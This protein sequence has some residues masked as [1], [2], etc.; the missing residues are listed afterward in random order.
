MD[1]K[2]SQSGR[3]VDRTNTH[4]TNNDNNNTHHK[5]LSRTTSSSTD[6]TSQSLASI[7]NNPHAV[8]SGLYDPSSWSGWWSSSAAATPL[9]F[10]PLSSTS[11]AAA[12]V[13]DPT[14]SD[15]QPYLSSISGP[16]GRFKDIRNHSNKESS[17]D[18]SAAEGKSSSGFGQGE[19]LVAC[20]REVPALYFKEDF[21]LEEGPTF[22]AA[23]P[24]S[25][26]SENLGLQEK[27]SQYLD[28]V[29]LHLVKEISLRSNSFFEA[30]GQLE[31]LNVKIAEGCS[32]IRELKET[33][34][35]LDS[36]LVDSARE[37][38]DL[39]LT[40][41]NLLALQQ[42]LRLILYVNQALSALTL[43]VSSADCAGAL[44]V[45]DDLQHLLDGNE[46][47]GLHC[48]R[49]LRDNVA[50]SIDAINS[51]T[52]PV[53]SCSILS[54]DF[55]RTS[56]H[57]AGN[58]DA[59]IMSRA[60]AS[61]PMNGEVD[62]VHIDEEEASSFRDR[63]LPLVIGL[64]RTAK[65]PSVLRIYRDTLTA[66]MKNAIKTAVADL[67]PLLLAQPLESD[68]APGERVVDADGGGSSLASKLR[69]MPPENFVQLLTAILRIVKAHLVRAAEV[70]KAI[71]WIMCNIGGHYAADS[72]AAAIAIGAVAAD[73]SQETDGQAGS[74]LTYSPQRNAAR[75]PSLQGIPN[76]ASGPSNMSKNFRADVLRENTEAVFAACD[77]AHGR[78]AK[79]L[80]VRALLHPKL[81]LQEFL[82]IYNL[83]Q[84]FIIATEKIGGR[85]GY[86]TRGTL[87]SQ[88]KAFVDYQHETRMT[89]IKAVLDQE[90]WVEVDVP[91]E[92][93][94]ILTSLFCSNSNGNVD[95]G[96]GEV[97]T[98]YTEAASSNE[99][100]RL[101][102]SQQH[103]ARTDYIEASADNTGQVKSLA[104]A[105]TTD[106]NISDVTTSPA[107]SNSTSNEERRR[108]SLQTLSFRGVDYHMVNC[109][110][111]LLKLLSEY[112]D[113]NNKLPMMSSE[114]VSGLRSITSK[115]LAL[116]SQVVSFTHAIIPEIRNI[117]F[118]KVPETRKALLLS[119]IDRVAQD[120]KVHRDE[121]HTKLV[122]IMRERLLVHLRSLPQIVEGWNRLEES[123]SQPSQFARSLTK[124]VGYL[125]RVLSR[126][127]H[128]VDVQAIFRQVV[129]I[130][131]SQISEAFSNIDFSSQ[132]A[133]NRLFRDIQ[134][135]LGC[136]RSLPSDNPS[137]AVIPNW[138]QLDEFLAQRFGPD[139]G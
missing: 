59:A 2:P 77:A 38:Q 56:I 62:E 50:A 68:L 136:I 80:G 116:A 117:L 86:S 109:G 137:G 8:K 118:S 74:V 129:V 81:R 60:K 103:I 47:T 97:V 84:D 93:Q 113:M 34:R 125:Q 58:M 28:V 99:D 36:D 65:L 17:V 105:G 89:Y 106:N 101:P 61:L 73:A 4:H 26:V 33:I 78:W 35:L 132:Q 79:L 37:I 23:C 70:K 11:K 63:L 122:Q 10:A 64:L 82:N 32:R 25:T 133:K 102:N 95:D 7:L 88:A 49:H 124:E 92:F 41:S 16:H 128:E 110:L 115:H 13:P 6:V 71:E 9:D 100:T 111:M 55:M 104:V 52:Y 44:D 42:K 87:Q 94:A 22:R 138:G 43:L 96:Q 119:E 45:T 30:Q 69:I 21:A 75:M 121:I 31:D 39:N 126:T 14:R 72:V 107:Q 139:A 66:D 131:H 83:T 135:I 18:D 48:F 54:A 120:Y 123:D 90:T 57:D 5:P 67:L 40:R 114:V 127:L 46:L 1:S 29:E 19:A 108:A 3:F 85:L 130:F 76:D 134:H 24:F 98:R 91:D 15:F 53:H 27:L 51:G 12:S 20:L 112:I